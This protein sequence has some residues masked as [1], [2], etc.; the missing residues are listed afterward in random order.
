[1]IQAAPRC[2]PIATDPLELLI[3]PEVRSGEAVSTPVVSDARA[4]QNAEGDEGL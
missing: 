2:R 1:M 3:S 4:G